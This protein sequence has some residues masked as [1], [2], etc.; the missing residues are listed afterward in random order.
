MGHSYFQY[1]SQRIYDDS[2]GHL[3]EVYSQVNHS[4][5]FFLERN[6]GN[7]N[8]WNYYL[9]ADDKNW[10]L[11]FLNVRKKYWGF[12]DFYFLSENGRYVTSGGEIG[13]FALENTHDALFQNGEHI[14]ANETLPSGQAITIFAVPV[15]AGKWKGFSYSAIA[16]SYTNEDMVNSLDVEAFS[17]QSVCFV[18]ENT[19]RVLLS[20]QQGGSIFE[21]YL[22]YLQAASDLDEA[23]LEQLS[24]D[25][26]DGKSGVLSCSIGGTPQYVSYQSIGYQDCMLLGIV[27]ESAASASLLQIQRATIDVLV[28]I[29]LLLGSLIILWLV[30]SYHQKTKKSALELRYREMMFDTLSISVNDIFLMLDGKTFH[31]DYLSPNVERLLGIPQ[32]L[33]LDNIHLLYDSAVNVSGF[34]NSEEFDNIPIHS[35]KHFDAEHIH[36]VTGERLWY[37]DSIYHEN[38]QGM[39]KFFIV[40]SDR[41]HERQMN[42]HL[43]EAL[44]VAKSANEAKSHFLSNMSH[45]IRTPMNAIIGFSVLLAKDADK[46]DK[47][48]EYTRKIS[49][50][51]QHLLG[52]INDVL[53]MSKIES[54]KTSLNVSQ[55]SLP[56]LVEELYTILLPQAKA[57]KQI[58]E[59][60]TEG[61]LE[62][63]LVGDKLRLNQIL[64][65]LL[66]NAIKYTQDG[67]QIDFS[68]QSLPKTSTHYTSLRFVVKDNGLGMSKEFL[69]VV[70]E[71]FAREANSTISG[72]QG[73]G[74]GMAITKNL[75]ELM[76][77]T[78]GVE[79]YLGVGSTF[80]V[81]MSFALPA[82]K[83]EDDDFW[84]RQGIS[85]VLV[86]DDNETVCTDIQGMME[87]SG[88]DV[89]YVTD[90]FAAIDA[91]TLAKENNEEFN[92]ILLDWQMPRINGIETARKIREE[93][94]DSVPILILT[95]YDW[96]DIEYEARAAGIDA[97]LPK[98]FFVSNFKQTIEALGLTQEQ[99]VSEKDTL[100]EENALEGMK[101]LIVEDN[102]LN[103]EILS[104]MLSMEGAQCEL[105]ENGQVALNM[106][107]ESELDRYDMILMD[108]QMPVMNGYEATRAI[109]LCKHPR[110]ADIPIVAMTANAFAEDVREAFQSGMNAHLA[111][112]IDMDTVKEALLR[113]K[114][115]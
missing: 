39:E 109:R 107:E 14:M 24:K 38:I 46:P 21:N 47:V 62:E 41:T 74:L 70:F 72:I 50:S 86:V 92:I 64:I 2:T 99:N 17:G 27:P 9:K 61:R 11:D 83:E 29:F 25:W 108:I 31:A 53:D 88:V 3:V 66:S 100:K 65:N 48:K 103:A 54:G 12:S 102:E 16:I 19:G 97:F 93:V 35:S 59:V 106:F 37:R 80:T 15:E 1:I 10:I 4:F 75:V 79:S 58:F 87:G 32:R 49:S 69:D 104:E 85:C 81:E 22:S 98:P 8:D 55:F 89:K 45:D 20:T 60:Y 63:H 51:S 18:V 44:E 68:V 91:V 40:M 33:A 6:W 95:A 36:Q 76:G 7:L 105:A 114:K 43:Q 113:L 26:Q 110:A 82:V 67:G 90:G 13:K 28:K 71:P 23:K 30:Y 115:S 34:T 52:L 101:F 78:I 96:S 94:N 112:P 42:Q 77:G 56:E 84:L 73:T 5:S 57:K 111:K